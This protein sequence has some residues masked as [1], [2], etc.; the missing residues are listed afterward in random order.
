MLV[1][2]S[3][4]ACSPNKIEQSNPIAPT[5]V[6]L[7][8]VTSIDNGNTFRFPATV[9]AVKTIDVRFEVTGRLVQLDMPTGSIVKAGQLLAMIDPVPFERRVL[10]KQTKLTQAEREL[11]RVAS[12]FSKSLVSQSNMDDAKTSLE[13][14]RIELSD[15]QQDLSYTKIFA[16]FNAQISHRYV[17]NNSYISAGESVAR[18]Q[19]VSQMYFHFSVPERIFTANARRAIASAQIALIGASEQ[20]YDVEYVEH[21]AE[22]NAISQTYDVVFALAQQD[23]LVATPGAR[24]IAKV[25]LLSQ[26]NQQGLSVPINALVGDNQTG[27]YV[28]RYN[29]DDGSLTQLP[30]TVAS[31]QDDLAILSHGVVLGDLVVSAGAAKMYDGIIVKP[32]TGVR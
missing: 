21:A 4:S 10:E 18:L 19:D 8:A 29:A 25:T 22:P 6:K 30:V 20:W 3:L 14:V 31:I 12:M 16:P 17:E 28:W 26:A 2:L 1:T 23:E 13:L 24:A 9:S 5:V 15:A 11:T 32:F 7:S 27:F